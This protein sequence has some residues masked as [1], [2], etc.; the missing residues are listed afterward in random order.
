[1]NVRK[2][3][4]KSHLKFP[5]K[6]VH[7]LESLDVR[8]FRISFKNLE[9]GNLDPVDCFFDQDGN[10]DS[11]LGRPDRDLDRLIINHDQA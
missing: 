4:Q 11:D 10:R 3:L 2:L 7:F 8:C 9:G 6:G 1:M 5:E